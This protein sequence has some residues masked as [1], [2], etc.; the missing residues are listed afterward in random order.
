MLQNH[1][2]IMTYFV[3]VINSRCDH[4]QMTAWSLSSKSLVSK[5]LTNNILS[6][7]H[8][9]LTTISTE[10]ILQKADASVSLQNFEEIIFYY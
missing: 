10:T 1:L 7:S 8:H 2:K 3:F 4:K 9:P 6:F 5:G